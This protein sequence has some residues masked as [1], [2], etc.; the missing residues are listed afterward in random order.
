MNRLLFL[1]LLLTA[2]LSCKPKHVDHIPDF[3]PQKPQNY[4]TDQADVLSLEE[5]DT[6]NALLKNYEQNSS[7]QIFFLLTPSAGPYAY[8]DLTIQI[9]NDWKTGQSGKDNGVLGALF[10]DDHKI[11][12]AVGYGLEAQLTDGRVKNIIEYSAKPFLISENYYLALKYTIRDLISTLN[13]EASYYPEDNSSDEKGMYFMI[14]G[15]IWMITAPVISL[16]LQ[17]KT[18]NKRKKRKKKLRN[19]SAFLILYVMAILILWLFT[20][21]DRFYITNTS[22]YLAIAWFIQ[23]LVTFTKASKGN[24]YSTGHKRYRYGSGSNG[25]STYSWGGF[26]GGGGGSFGGGG[27]GGS[28]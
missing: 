27:A 23:I 12:I 14:I 2:F 22:I 1:C 13:G 8:D 26:S 11:F 16:F 5:E 20:K 3:I 24:T 10:I 18:R 17:P 7:N 19:I 21:P 15:V 4:I 6:L 25:R 9:A 28:W